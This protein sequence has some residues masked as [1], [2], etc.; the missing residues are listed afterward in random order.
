MFISTQ[1]ASLV[2]SAVGLFSV[3]P[4]ARSTRPID[5]HSTF[6][7]WLSFDRYIHAPSTSFSLR[8]ARFWNDILITWRTLSESCAASNPRQGWGVY[9]N[10]KHTVDGHHVNLIEVEVSLMM[11]WRHCCLSHLENHYCVK[12]WETADMVI[13]Q[14]STVPLILLLLKVIVSSVLPDA[15]NFAPMSRRK[16]QIYLVPPAMG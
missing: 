16:A 13:I 6:D 14:L 11:Q 5:F 8:T 1:F 7:L 12:N 15:F 9:F 3:S 2:R 10:I 4:P